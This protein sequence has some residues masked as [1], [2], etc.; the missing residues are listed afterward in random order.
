MDHHIPWF[1]QGTSVLPRHQWPS[2]WALE[3]TL[4]RPFKPCC[5]QSRNRG[6]Q[7]P[8]Q[9]LTLIIL[10][11]DVA[12]V[13]ARFRKIIM[14]LLSHECNYEYTLPPESVQTHQRFSPVDRCLGTATC[15]QNHRLRRW[16]LWL[17][18]SEP[19][20]T[21]TRRARM[22]STASHQQ[23]GDNGRGLSKKIF[24][25]CRQSKNMSKQLGSM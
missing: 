18:L 3:A 7:Y 13:V 9:T 2:A 1:C 23:S 12:I 5:Q 10:G 16:E 20:P 11:S 25:E 6:M 17:L 19:V 21:T 15:V 8:W 24:R 14:Y 4:R 22:D